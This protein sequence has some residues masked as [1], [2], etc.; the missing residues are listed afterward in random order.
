[1]Q[2]RG[3]APVLRD[4]LRADD[5]GG[6]VGVHLHQASRSI[7]SCVNLLSCARRSAADSAVATAAQL[8]AGQHD[9]H[10]AAGCAVLSPAQP[11]AQS[12]PGSEQ[13]AAL[14]SAD[15]S[16]KHTCSSS[17]AREM[18]ITPAEQPMPDRL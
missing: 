15:H 6:A 16:P 5:Q 2:V 14:S 12:R 9:L 18:E 10:G 4:V 11:K 1:M 17:R 8:D 7:S 3:G 13:Q